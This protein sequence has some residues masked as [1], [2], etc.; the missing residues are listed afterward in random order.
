MRPFAKLIAMLSL[1]SL[2]AACSSLPARTLEAPAPVIDT[3]DTMLARTARKLSDAHAELSGIYPLEHGRDALIA[4]LALAM[5]AEKTLDLQY[6]IW[7]NDVTG[8]LVTAKVLEAADRGVKVR[9][10]LD[11]VGSK[12]DDDTLLALSGH[13]NIEVRLFNPV[14]QRWLR[15][16]G[17]VLEFSRVNRRMHNKSFTA[18]DH[19]TI[20]GGRNIGDEYFEANPEIDFSDLDVL[21]V[22]PVVAQ[23]ETSFDLYWRH[24][25]AI[26]INDFYPRADTGSKL[27]DL[28]KTLAAQQQLDRATG[29]LQ[30]LEKD[31]LA[32]RLRDASLPFYWGNAQALYDHPDKLT[33][34]PAST[35]VER[36]APVA[37]QTDRS[38]DIVSPYFVPGKGGTAWLVQRAAQGTRVRVLT[39]SLAATDVGMVHAGYAPYRK[40]LLKGGISLYELKPDPANPRP[41]GGS[42]WTGSSRASLHAKS[43]IFDRRY[44]FI[45]SL[46]LDPRSIELNTEIGILLDSPALADHMADQFDELVADKAYRL[47]LDDGNLQWHEPDGDAVH[48]HDPETSLLRRIG[49]DL[50]RLLPIESQL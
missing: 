25:R 4:R 5:T 13:P 8:R 1:S 11:D 14:S 40:P 15:T 10:L 20:V 35:L 43:F 3:H 9:V 12:P 30:Q 41:K 18:D 24:Q 37:A 17:M 34:R 2:L 23:V 46:N 36:L 49:V 48:G 22:G 26:P 47:T 21:A 32:L 27:L 44:V 33:E 31:A 42:G 19:V 16:L 7:H 50:L 28:R 39:N 6:Y 29:Y 38:L 45:G